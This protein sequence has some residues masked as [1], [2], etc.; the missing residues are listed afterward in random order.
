MGIEV[1]NGKIGRIY[2]DFGRVKNELIVAQLSKL[3]K[4]S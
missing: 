1:S 4:R 2:L 3:A